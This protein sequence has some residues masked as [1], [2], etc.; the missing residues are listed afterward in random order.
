MGLNFKV[1]GNFACALL[2]SWQPNIF[3]SLFVNKPLQAYAL[4]SFYETYDLHV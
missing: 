3:L 2:D 4:S 1:D